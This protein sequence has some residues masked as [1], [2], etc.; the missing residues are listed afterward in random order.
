MR[1]LRLGVGAYALA[2]AYTGSDK[3]LAAAGGFLF[4][5]AL[6]NVGCCGSGACYTTPTVKRS[7]AGETDEI[8]FEEVKP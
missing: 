4:L 5:T 1:W 7:K 2:S 3:L 6:F 8:V